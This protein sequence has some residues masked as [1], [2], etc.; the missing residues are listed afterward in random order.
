LVAAGGFLLRLP[1][2]TINFIERHLLQID[3]S[4]ADSSSVGTGMDG[5]TFAPGVAS[6]FAEYQSMADY[7]AAPQDADFEVV[8]L[9]GED[10]L[11]GSPRIGFE[12]IRVIG[13]E[14]EGL[15][16]RAAKRYALE[17]PNA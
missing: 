8:E 3:P 12:T 1:P 15:I 6:F 14:A 9:P 2:A 10:L 16:A 5:D 13:F 7:S 4:L 17:L 11:V